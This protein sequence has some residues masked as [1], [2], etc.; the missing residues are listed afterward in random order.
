MKNK[1]FIT[2]KSLIV[3]VAACCAIF[4][5]LIFFLPSPN[6]TKGFE[7][8]REL[9]EFSKT[10][11]EWIKME[12][13]DFFKPRYDKYY[14]SKFGFSL[15]NSLVRKSN[16]FFYR[17]GL[18]HEPYFS[19]IFFK[20][21]LTRVVQY[22]LNNTL[23]GNFVQKIE[24]KSNS[25]LVVFGVVQGAFHGMVRYFEQLY[26]L[27][28]IDEN[29]K[30]VCP[31]DY[32]VLL[33]NVVNRSPYT[34][35]MLSLVL[36]LLEVNPDNVVYLRGS[37]EFY[38]YWK[39]HTLNK[40]LDFR[41]ALM[42]A[43]KE[44]MTNLINAFFNTLPLALY[45]TI[46]EDISEFVSYLKISHFQSDTKFNKLINEN[47]YPGFIFE[48]NKKKTEFLNVENSAGFPPVIKMHKEKIKLKSV[49]TDI[50]KRTQY[51]EMDGLRLLDINDGVT[52]W[53]ILS[54]STETYRLGAKFFYD[55]FTIINRVK[56]LD[57]WIITLYKRDIRNKN[58]IIFSKRKVH[59]FSGKDL[60]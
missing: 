39:D 7:N 35:E 54:T 8:L 32:I 5:G 46:N 53:N 3:V 38:D 37:N 34:L 24:L 15:I 48:K 12:S 49:I 30:L 36:K 58:D 27:K 57:D 40:E 4:A 44:K 17:I 18:I 59:L 45:V 9:Q 55:A 41:S 51:E 26:K 29:L 21:I 22:R 47:E 25:K 33:G 16:H 42:D 13:D 56:D 19:E 2:G 1:A 28:I 43:T 31:D 52:H 20:N 50:L 60:K 14:D 10:L 11:D 23:T 6:Y